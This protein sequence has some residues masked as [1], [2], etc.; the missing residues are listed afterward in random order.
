MGIAWQSGGY[1]FVYGTS[2]VDIACSIPFLYEKLSV[3][4]PAE[5]TET[6]LNSDILNDRMYFDINLKPYEAKVYMVHE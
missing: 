4:D 5:G 2:C 6:E 3:L 1:G